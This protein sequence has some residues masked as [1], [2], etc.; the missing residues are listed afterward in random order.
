MGNKRGGEKM[1]NQFEKQILLALEKVNFK[2]D[3]QDER[4]ANLEEIQRLQGETLKEQTSLI[5]S[6]ENGQE[7]LNAELSQLRLQNA[8]EF[9]EIK[10]QLKGMED[11]FDLLREETWMNKKDIKRI[12][13]TMGMC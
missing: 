12:Q 8:K 11:N 6:L 3:R 7:S 13:K 4:L 1:D 2:L 5:S 10:E 9:G